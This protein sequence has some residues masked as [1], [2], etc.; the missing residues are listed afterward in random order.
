MQDYQYSTKKNKDINKERNLS[1]DSRISHKARIKRLPH[2]HQ[3]SSEM[4]EPSESR[5]KYLNLLQDIDKLCDSYEQLPI[6]EFESDQEQENESK[7]QEIAKEEKAQDYKLNFIIMQLK[8]RIKKHPNVHAAYPS[9]NRFKISSE[10]EA[11]IGPGSY[12]S[13][14]VSQLEGYEFSNI[15]RLFT[16]IAHTMHIIESIYPKHKEIPEDTIIRKN[17]FLATN[18]N[19]I[20]EEFA[21]RINYFKLKEKDVKLRK[22]FLDQKTFSEKKEKLKEK[23]RKFEWRMTKEEV[24]KSQKT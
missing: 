22:E 24:A 14:A 12:K 6:I 10:T 18:P 16:P 13:G 11:K 5:G 20:K 19:I 8:K 17:K 4:T 7:I 15:P 9:S 21:S 2:I 23:L 3:N 1:Y